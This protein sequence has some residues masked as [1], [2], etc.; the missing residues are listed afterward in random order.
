MSD[1]VR[2]F[3]RTDFRRAIPRSVASISAVRSAHDVLGS[4]GQ[5][6]RLSLLPTTRSDSPSQ[7]VHRSGTS[8]VS[9]FHRPTSP[10][11]KHCSCGHDHDSVSRTPKPD[12]GAVSGQFCSARVVSNRSACRRSSRLVRARL[13]FCVWAIV[14]RPTSAW[15]LTPGYAM[16]RE[17][18][19]RVSAVQGV[20]CGLGS[21]T[22]GRILERS[23]S[24]RS[25]AVCRTRSSSCAPND[26]H[27]AFA[28][29]R[30]ARARAPR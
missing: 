26:R 21:G 20:S 8:G 30:S 18:S 4:I 7:P 3:T 5:H 28:A 13:V 12:N 2:F 17:A 15:L 23:T 11:P 16:Y 29:G 24:R 9:A 10:S 19:L 25:I 27:Q 22:R 14:A 6:L 1:R